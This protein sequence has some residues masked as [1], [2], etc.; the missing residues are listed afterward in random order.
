MTYAELYDRAVELG[1]VEQTLGQKA[2]WYLLQTSPFAEYVYNGIRRGVACEGGIEL[3]CS[4]AFAAR[5][6][7]AGYEMQLVKL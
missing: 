7:A 5:V 6:C 1:A 2:Q 3:L 4:Q